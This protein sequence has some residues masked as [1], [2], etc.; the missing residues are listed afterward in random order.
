[1]AKTFSALEKNILKSKGLS[2]AQLKKLAKAGINSREDFKTVGDAGTLADLVSG[3]TKETAAAVMSWAAGG[4]VPIV[5]AGGGGSVV[6]DSPDAVYCIHCRTKQPKDY[7]S[8]D[9]CVSCGKQAEPIL[10]CYWCSSSGPG[11]FCRQ[12]GAEFVATAELDLAIH[13]KREGLSKD[14]VPKKLSGMSAA[15]KDALWG[16]IRKSRG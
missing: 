3:I 11:K 9:L 16:R 13:L 5:A 7:H 2:E 4:A 8:G 14:D 10:S 12:C 1:M 6:L 15:E